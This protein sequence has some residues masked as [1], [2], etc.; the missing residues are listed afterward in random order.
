MVVNSPSKKGRGGGI[1]GVPLD[2][3][4]FDS[5]PQRVRLVHQR[6][7]QKSIWA[8]GNQLKLA[9]SW[10]VNV[11]P[12]GPRTPPRNSRGPVWSGLM[13]THWFPLIR[14]AIKT[15]ISFRRGPGWRSPWKVDTWPF[16]TGNSA[17]KR[18]LFGARW[19]HVCHGQ[20]S[21][22]IGDGRPPT[23]NRNPYNGAL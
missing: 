8:V 18:D 23:F 3:H 22:F 9:G 20:K 11:P 5:N 17:R 19:V 21:R 10:L 7:C 12:P 13:K 14:P 15:L 16:R 6:L 2:S 4:D 1:G